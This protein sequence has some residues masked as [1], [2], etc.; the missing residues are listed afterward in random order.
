MMN[1]HENRPEE[2]LETQM[3]ISH[4]WLQV[5]RLREVAGQVGT[6]C[7]RSCCRLAIVLEGCAACHLQAS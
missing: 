3:A 5:G 4:V 7:Y 6:F 2:V 1:S